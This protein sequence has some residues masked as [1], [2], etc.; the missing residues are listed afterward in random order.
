MTCDIS[1]LRIQQ[2]PRAILGFGAAICAVA[3][4]LARLVTA[5]RRNAAVRRLNGLS[6]RDLTIGGTSRA[7]EV[8][9]IFD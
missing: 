6:D 3:V 9:R 7:G 2:V 4:T 5:G 8:A 1:T